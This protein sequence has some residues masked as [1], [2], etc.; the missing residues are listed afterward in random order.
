MSIRVSYPFGLNLNINRTE[1]EF[2]QTGIE[3]SVQEIHNVISKTASAQI[4]L[5]KNK[6]KEFTGLN[7]IEKE[8]TSNILKVGSFYEG[9]KLFYPDEFDYILIFG[10]FSLPSNEI[11]V[12][13]H[14]FGLG[15]L[16]INGVFEGILS[17][18]KFFFDRRDAGLT[19]IFDK[20][21]TS[22]GSAI[23][24][25]YTYYKQRVKETD[26]YV[27]V[28]PAFKIMDKQHDLKV[29]QLCSLPDFTNY[30]AETGSFLVTR[31]GISFT[32]SEVRFVRNWLSPKHFQAY[33]M[34]KYLI[35]GHNDG[36]KLKEFCI[37]IHINFIHI[38]SY[39]IKTCMLFHQYKCAEDNRTMNRC[40]CDVICDIYL[41]WKNRRWRHLVKG[42]DNDEEYKGGYRNWYRCQRYRKIGAELLENILKNLTKSKAS[43]DCKNILSIE[44][45]AVSMLRYIEVKNVMEDMIDD[46]EM[47]VGI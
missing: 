26:I 31:F 14:D 38:A 22:K 3:T 15:S 24:L 44:P 5:Q 30:L 4:E 9:T 37:K 28:L 47:L 35:N 36:E 13:R 1:L 27:D 33:K 25:K 12:V 20:F 8:T 21:V 34:L 42:L 43:G 17:C 46:V 19:L 6:L 32:E 41:S 11:D 40:I 18:Y 29:D 45:W 39:K 10:T 23:K 16:F 7:L 2:V